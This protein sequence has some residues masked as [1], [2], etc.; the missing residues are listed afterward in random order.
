[1]VGSYTIRYSTPCG[2]FFFNSSIVLRTVDE[3]C[4]AFDPGAWKMPMP[5]ASLL[6]SSER[7]AI[8]AGGELE[9]GHVTQ[10]RGLAVRARLEDDLAE[11]LLVEQPAARVDA[12]LVVDRRRHRRRSDRATRHLDVLLADRVHH[13]AGGE[14]ARRHLAR[15]QPH[16][17]GVVAATE[18]LD[19]AHAGNAADHVL[20]LQEAV[21]PEV[22]GVV[23]VVRRDQVH[24]HD[25]VGRALH[26]G[27][28]ELADLLGQARERLAHP[29]LHLHLRE[30]DVGADP[31]RDRQGQHAVRG[32]RGRHVE[33]VLD[34]IDLLLERRRDRLGR[35]P[36]D[37]R[38][39]RW[40]ARRPTAGRHRDTR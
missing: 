28:A 7:S 11:F 35:A 22:H 12:E 31:E 16:P 36:G 27:D 34:A 39:D 19:L 15:I 4:S 38:R 14:T 5:T 18:Y 25:E 9:P 32:G 29:V 21:V 20:D 3:S 1:M 24:H 37:W 2:K 6:L 33:H 26:R 13:V 30:I 23:P 40:H 8:V 10:P 17:H